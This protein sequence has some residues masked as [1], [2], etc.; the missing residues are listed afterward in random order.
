MN[1]LQ[2][3]IHLPNDLGEDEESDL[4]HFDPPSSSLHTHLL[5]WHLK[6]LKVLDFVLFNFPD[7]FSVYLFFFFKFLAFVRIDKDSGSR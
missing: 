3:H 2:P 6:F 5:A 1:S 4:Q 7:L